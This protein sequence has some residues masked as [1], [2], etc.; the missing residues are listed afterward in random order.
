MLVQ[1]ILN[2]T[3]QLDIIIY[4]KHIKEL[5]VNKQIEGVIIYEQSYEN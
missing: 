3:K 1:N 4:I 5:L 2:I